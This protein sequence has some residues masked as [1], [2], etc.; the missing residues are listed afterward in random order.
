TAMA[1]Q[2][3]IGLRLSGVY[4]FAGEVSYQMPLNNNRLELDL[5]LH[6]F[7]GWNY[8]HVSGVYQWLW[9][10]MG[11]LNW[12]AGVGANVGLYT[13]DESGLGLGV[14][15]QVGIEYDFD[16]PLQLSIDFRPNIGLD[17]HSG[18]GWGGI[19][20]GVRYRLN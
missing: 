10:I 12:Y 17:G 8:I 9:N 7:E 15:G 2:H 18:F 1:Q 4:G 13:G 3:N 11:G 6:N 16:F 5:G 14:A 19:C 20:L